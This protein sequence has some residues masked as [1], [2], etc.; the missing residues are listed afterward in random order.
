MARVRILN[1]RFR[2]GG[3]KVKAGRLTAA[4]VL[5]RRGG[6]KGGPARARALSSGKRTQIASHAAKKR[7][8]KTT[9]Y[10]KPAFYKRKVR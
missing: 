1:K 8:G 10:S 5:G 9:A 4:V 7:W 3:K 2:T 6:K